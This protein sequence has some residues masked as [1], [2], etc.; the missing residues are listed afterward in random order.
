MSWY[1]KLPLLVLIFPLGVYFVIRDARK[2]LEKKK[3][4]D[5]SPEGQKIL[6]EK[7]AIKAQVEVEVEAEVE[8]E[9]DVIEEVEK[10][11][12]TMSNFKKWEYKSI[13][14]E[15]E[16][17]IKGMLGAKFRPELLEGDLNALGSEGWEMVGIAFNDGING[18]ALV[19]KREI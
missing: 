11:N 19:F 3:I 8:A 16:T 9:N 14:V 13:H 17:Y 6:R 5:A 4:F 7:A 1:L 10:R 12:M 2:G 18:A 15:R